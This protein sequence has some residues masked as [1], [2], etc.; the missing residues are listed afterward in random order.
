MKMWQ[1]LQQPVPV[2]F[3][4]IVTAVLGI[5]HAWSV[6][7]EVNPDGINYL[8]LSDAVLEG[9]WE[10]LINASWSPLYPVL[11]GVSRWIVRP[12]PYWEFATAHLANLILFLL[13]LAAFQ[14]FLRQLIF[15]Y[16]RCAEKDG[17]T[18]LPEWAWWLMGHVLFI[19]SSLN[20][21]M[22]Y[23][24][25]PDMCVSLIV[26]LV[27]GLLL[28]MKN[29]QQTWKSFSLMGL[30]L[31]VGFLAKTI[32][33]PLT[34][35]FLGLA[36]FTGGNPRKA[37]PKAI[38][39]FLIFLTVAG[40]FVVNLS[41]KK[42]RFTYG[43]A[44]TLNYAWSIN[45]VTQLV[46]WQ[47]GPPGSGMPEHPTRKIRE[48]PAVY[49]FA[50]PIG[51]T[52][53]P[54]FD[55]AY[56][57]EGVVTY[58][59]LPGH[60]ITLF[61]ALRTYY[62]MFI[63]Q[64]GIF[65]GWLI[66]FLLGVRV[67]G[68]INLNA[69]LEAWPL[70]IPSF[71]VLGMYALVSPGEPRYSVPFLVLIWLGLF[72]AC[73]LP[74]GPD[75]QRLI[76]AVVLAVVISVAIPVGYSTTRAVA[77]GFQPFISQDQSAH[78]QWEITDGLHQIGIRPGE[79]VAYLRNSYRVDWARLARVKIISE[80]PPSDVMQFWSANEREKSEVIETLFSTGARAIIAETPLDVPVKGW[81]R[82]GQTE[83][84]ARILDR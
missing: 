16:R 8:D 68:R 24:L 48:N 80:I 15:Y 83:Y 32:M 11:L 50:T 57:H 82:I 3:C 34:F 7:H 42:G 79:Q 2:V 41:T 30:C 29:Q 51:G 63:E 19:W 62:E 27:S 17:E 21:T 44:G 53:P 43:D 59:D 76:A 47:G 18:S 54:G 31:G 56:W 9:N 10:V 69:I 72:G 20:L 84:Y 70:F 40:P 39:A 5:V 46:H 6:R 12:S 45:G 22:M 66:L 71:A 65:V 67:R 13:T 61:K 58:F 1:R 81:K 33:F 28:R 4:W 60:L 75:H 36:L 74:K 52:F 26:Y 55:Y 73:R 14:F 23:R 35:I 49:E 38:V 25:E 64:G 37:L 78:P 77:K